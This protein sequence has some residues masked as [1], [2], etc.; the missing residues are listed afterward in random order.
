MNPLFTLAKEQW[1]DPIPSPPGPLPQDA[2]GSMKMKIEFLE[3]NLAKA[4]LINEALWELIRDKLSVTQ[5]EFYQKLYEIDLRDGDLDGKNQRQV[6]ECPQCKRKVSPLHSACLYC[7]AV[8]DNS[9][10]RMSR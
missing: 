3:A 6:I 7:G 9:V 4:L 1:I 8:I 10:F 5:E 2:P